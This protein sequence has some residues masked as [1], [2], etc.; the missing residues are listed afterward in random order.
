M[1]IVAVAI[2]AQIRCHYDFSGAMGAVYLPQVLTRCQQHGVEQ[3]YDRVN[4]SGAIRAW[5]GA[6]TETQRTANQPP[7][8]N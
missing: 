3:L 4:Q 6:T 7:Q 1:A 2:V 8:L 5:A